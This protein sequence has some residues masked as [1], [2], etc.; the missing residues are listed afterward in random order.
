MP[1][2]GT[3]EVQT[4]QGDAMAQMYPERLPGVVRETP[5]R[6]AEAKVYEALRDGL[7]DAFTC[8]YSVAWVAKR[9]SEGARDGEVDFVVAHPDLSLLVLEVKGGGIAFDAHTGRWTSTD[10]HGEVHPIHDPVGQARSSKYVLLDKLKD[11]PRWRDRYLGIGH[12]VFLPDVHG[13]SVPLR[14]DMDPAMVLAREDLSTVEAS[15]RSVFDYWKGRDERWV[16]L[17]SAGVE[18]VRALLARSFTIPCPL[19]VVLA[20]EDRRVLELTEQEFKVLDHLSRLPRV[21]VQGGA[22]TGKTMLALEKAKRLAGEGFR[23]LLTCYNRPLA[24]HLARSVGDLENLDVL[25]FHQLCWRKA[26]EAGVPLADPDSADLGSD[27]YDVVMPEALVAALDKLEDRYDAVVVDE[28]Q[29]FKDDW[30]VPLQCCLTHPDTGVLYVFADSNQNIYR[31]SPRFPEGLAEIPL[32]ENL[33]NTRAIHELA[34]RFYSNGNF[35]GAGPEGRAVEAVSLD[36]TSSIKKAVGKALH[37]LI[38]EESVPPC[39]IAVL[40]GRGPGRFGLGEDGKI[41]AFE[42][43]DDQERDPQKVLL[44]TIYR[45]KG[46]ERRICILAGL[47]DM[48]EESA[49]GLLYVGITRART[50]LV[51]VAQPETLGPL[52]LAQD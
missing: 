47:D 5:G 24:D 36:E 9:G 38:R 17:G 48:D 2:P 14:P 37:R 50:H 18:A 49:D 51:V 26:E 45:F 35:D 41:G 13:P 3:R 23:T 52:G 34:A 11:L 6:A 30:W 8:F 12:A 27:Y 21:L 39:E 43:T 20:E 31:R 4:K 44:Q 29:D 15:I 16:P 28:G 25:N 46:L 7:P 19:G 10:R 1:V 22:G 33:R 32:T 42:V 40:T